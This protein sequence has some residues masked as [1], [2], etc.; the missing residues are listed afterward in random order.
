M[1]RPVTDD[2]IATFE[3]DGVVPLRQIHPTEWV[4]DLRVHLDEVFNRTGEDRDATWTG[5][6]NTGD[7]VDMAEVIGSYRSGSPD[8]EIA[9]EGGPGATMTGRSIVETDPAHW[10]PGLRR[11]HLE[12]PL[13]DV[14]AQL[15]GSAQVNFYCD[16]VFLKEPGSRTQTP[17]HQDMPYF[18]V[19]GGTV[20]VCWVP[21][22][23]VTIETGAMGYVLGSHKW[24]RT[25]KLSDFVTRTGTFPERGGIDLSGLE[26]LPDPDEFADDLRYFDAEP[27]DVIVHHWATI[28]GSSGNTSTDRLRR[29]ASIRYAGEGC[30]FYK[31]PSSPEPFRHTVGLKNGDPLE[32][33]DRFPIVWPRK[34]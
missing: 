25:F 21:V 8:A 16:Q 11:H 13:P 2:E 3:R 4:D 15:T 20:A 6:S 26:T 18:V 29:A 30:Y 10:H 22:D 24:G 34:G 5:S 27:G 23:H 12:S 14:V 32:L 1:S 17:F 9:L 7:R 19:D 28:H 31:R 33:A